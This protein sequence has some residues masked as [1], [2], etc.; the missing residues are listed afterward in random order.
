MA[1]LMALRM[2]MDMD[3]DMAKRK[4][5]SSQQPL[6]ASKLTTSPSSSVCKLTCLATIAPF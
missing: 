6:P 5:K 4:S 3:M 2:D 1:L